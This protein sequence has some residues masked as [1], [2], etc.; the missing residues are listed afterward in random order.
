MGGVG[1]ENNVAGARVG[2]ASVKRA[3]ASKGVG[4][5]DAVGRGYC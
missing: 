1:V 3:V 2:R 4:G 5:N